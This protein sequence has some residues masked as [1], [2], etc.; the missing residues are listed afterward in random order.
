M[1]E[2]HAITSEGRAIVQ[3]PA[4]ATAAAVGWIFALKAS[5]NGVFAR[6]DTV[7]SVQLSSGVRWRHSGVVVE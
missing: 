4:A 2:C 6:N 3:A 1:S 5:W 7:F